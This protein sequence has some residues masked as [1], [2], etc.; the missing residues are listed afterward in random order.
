MLS[1]VPR[2]LPPSYSVAMMAVAFIYVDWLACRSARR[3]SHASLHRWYSALAITHRPLINYFSRVLCATGVFA[4]LFCCCCLLATCCRCQ[5]HVPK[6]G[7]YYSL[8]PYQHCSPLSYA[9]TRTYLGQAG[10]AWG[11]A[12]CRAAMA[13]NS[14]LHISSA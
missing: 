6:D 2:Q 1:S 7:V 13:S 4:A 12:S 14:A 3:Y 9:L 10:R 8:A 11:V 5:N